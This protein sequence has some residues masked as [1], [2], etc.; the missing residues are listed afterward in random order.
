MTEETSLYRQIHP[1]FVQNGHPSYIAFRPFPRDNDQLS[2][3][4]GDLITAENAHRHYTD[5]QKLKSCGVMSVTVRECTALELPTCSSPE[6][7]PEHAHIDFAGLDK[8]QIDTKSKGLLGS[9]LARDW[10]YRKE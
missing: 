7:F 1:N 3:Y 4:D 2:V 5:V 6:Q 9:A 8:R 10:V